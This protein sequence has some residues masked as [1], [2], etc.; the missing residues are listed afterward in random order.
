MSRSTPPRLK[1]F[2]LGTV[3]HGSVGA[4][5]GDSFRCD[6]Q[7]LLA[8]RLLVQANAGSGKSWILRRILEE[9]HGY[10]Q[11]IV[12]D[13]EGEFFSLRERFDYIHAA[14]EGGDIVAH[15][16]TA[17]LLAERLLELH[18]SAILD[19]YELK[20]HER[21][22]FVK[23]FLEAMIDARKELWHPVLVV[24]DEA[25][26]FA[27]QTGK[28]ESTEAVIELASRGRK[29]G[30]CAIL[31]TQRL[32]KLHKDA[33]A[34]LANKLVGR[35]TLDIDLSRAADE[36]GLVNKADQLRL[37]ALNPGHFFAL[38]GAFNV[39]RGV[40][41]KVG[42]VRT[43]HPKV[44]IDTPT[45][46]PAPANVRK[47]LA[48]FADLPSEAAAREKSLAE[49]TREL[50][51]A[52]RTITELRRGHPAPAAAPPAPTPKRVEVPV[53]TPEQ[54]ADLRTRNAEL[55]EL[56]ERLTSAVQAAG[57]VAAS[58]SQSLERVAPAAPP[59]SAGRASTPSPGRRP[60]PPPKP[61]RP[62]ADDITVPQQRI[63]NAVAWLQCMGKASDRRLVAL[64][65]NASPSS[66]AYANNLGALRT[67]KLITYPGTGKVALT[68]AG[69]A[70]AEPGDAPQTSASLQEQVLQMLPRPRAAIVEALVGVYPAPMGKEALAAAVGASATSSAF[71]NNLGGLRSLGFLDYPAQGEVVAT[72][73]LFVDGAA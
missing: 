43:S 33:A 40:I 60:A 3:H 63:L 51:A 20:H 50:E 17:K 59:S 42:P 72:S 22:L 47:L 57:S 70:R 14:A 19:L 28:A 30:F 48:R 66:S 21:I 53:I 55:G 73:V 23:N 5:V 8:S 2:E 13:I 10:V 68:D 1:N 54:L 41:V 34:D 64:M 24:V 67:K 27:P 65:A 12:L 25:H 37:R 31:A 32:A 39:P 45:P 26:I 44:G 29:R 62:A 36:L 52:K 46:P 71:A 4:A 38:G 7:G 11:Q 9:T 6:L 15:P 49:L 61:P 18:V 35:T 16:K 69:L 58:L 56:A